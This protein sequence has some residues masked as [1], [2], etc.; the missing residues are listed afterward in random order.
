MPKSVNPDR[1]AA[2]K[3]VVELDADDL[4]VLD[5]FVADINKRGA[6]QRFVYPAFNMPFG[7]PDKS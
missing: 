4:K 3:E 6:W 1:I 5:D 2:N 7:F